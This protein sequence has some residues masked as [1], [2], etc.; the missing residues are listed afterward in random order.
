MMMGGV[1]GGVAEPASKPGTPAGHARGEGVL[2]D[3]D[4]WWWWWC[5]GSRPAS[6]GRRPATHEEEVCSVMMMGGVGGGVAE[7]GQQAWDAGRPRTT[8]RC[9]P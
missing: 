5:G 7:A 6:L 1:G 8:R 4:G 2:R 9:A 3:D